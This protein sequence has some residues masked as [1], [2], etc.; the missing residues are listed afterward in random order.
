MLTSLDSMIRQAAALRYLAAKRTE[1]TEH[2]TW[3]LDAVTY[4]LAACV[5]VGIAAMLLH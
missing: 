1:R 3:W 4:A 2:A 5:A